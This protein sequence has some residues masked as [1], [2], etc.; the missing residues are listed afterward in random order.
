MGGLISFEAV[1]EQRSWSG[2][3][4]RFARTI[5]ALL[6]LCFEINERK[7]AETA[8][9]DE[10]RFTEAIFSSLP[11]ILYA[12][13]ED[14]HFVRWNRGWAELVGRSDEE[15]RPLV[16]L[17]TVSP[18][19]RERVG[20]VIE[21]V[22]RTGTGS[23]EL[24]ILAGDGREL[25]YYCRGVRMEVGGK[26]YVVGVGIGIAE[27][28]EA[29]KALE[30]TRLLLEAVLEQ[31]PVPMAVASEPDGMIL[32][33]NR[34]ITNLL[35]YEDD[36]SSV[37]GRTIAEVVQSQQWHD[38]YAD[39]SKMTVDNL[40]IMRALRGE[41]TKNLEYYVVRN[42]G[43]QRWGLVSA[44]PIYNH[45]GELV[46]GLVIIP[47]ITQSKQ[48]E[49]RA[50]RKTYLKE[51]LLGANSL[52]EKLRLVTDA[53]VELLDADFARIWMIDH[54]DLCEVG[55]PHAEVIEGSCT[56]RNRSRCLHLMASSGRYTHIDGFH[57]RGTYGR[58]QAW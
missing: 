39:G 1:G 22:F 35:G 58:M 47:D 51:Q 19:D 9:I 11:G 14:G 46:A 50:K 36:A 20:R 37:L 25:P 57:R 32:Y 18:K 10:K 52:N 45:A 15:M 28:K 17:D 6:S 13:E 53:T 4:E 31:S 23:T 43:T 24:A 54:G 56:C 40:P 3:D 29:E 55:C 16:A 42:D 12:F 8:L 34:A 7:R 49:E 30:N 2:E 41:V 44:T 33:I 26:R 38:Y 27:R 21:D 5:A 48:A